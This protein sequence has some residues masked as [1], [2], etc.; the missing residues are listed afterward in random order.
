MLRC[1]LPAT[2]LILTLLSPARASETIIMVFSGGYPPFYSMESPDGVSASPLSGAFVEFLNAFE[3]ENPHY[4]I[5]KKR[6]PRARMDDALLDGT[7]HAFSLNSPL[8][9]DEENRQHFRFSTPIWRTGDHLIVLDDSSI[10]SPDP[11][12][13][14]GKRLGIIH[15]NGYGPLDDPIKRGR[16]K[17]NAVYRPEQLM[18]MLLAGRIDGYVGNRH[19]E[20]FIWMQKRSD[21]DRFKRLDPPLYEFDLCVMVRKDCPEFLDALNT[22]IARSRENGFLDGLN[23]RYFPYADF[24]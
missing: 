9:V 8:F 13:L 10:R 15:G 1:L 17:A 11:V 22:F 6:L 7:A 4:A 5:R 18:D 14:E 21:A 3:R 16:I 12:E 2:L 23:A 24:R 19:T 20:P